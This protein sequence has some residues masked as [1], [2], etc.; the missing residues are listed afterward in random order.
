[1]L[2]HETRHLK[3]SPRDPLTA[4]ERQQK[5]DMCCTGQ[6]PPALLETLRVA[7]QAPAEIASLRKFMETFA[8]EAG[9]DD[10]QRFTR[11]PF[12]ISSPDAGRTEGV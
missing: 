12:P 1:V 6:M 9:S 7:L 2:E 3:G 11:P 4:A 8:F 5:F 10:G